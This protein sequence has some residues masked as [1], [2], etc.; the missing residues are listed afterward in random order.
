MVSVFTLFSFGFKLR[1]A[2]SFQEYFDPDGKIFKRGGFTK[3][4]KDC[5]RDYRKITGE[6]RIG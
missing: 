1:P 6:R 4:I 2:A 3:F 5:R